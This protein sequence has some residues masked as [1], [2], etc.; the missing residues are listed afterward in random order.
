MKI[1]NKKYTVLSTLAA[2]IVHSLELAHKTSFRESFSIL[3]YRLASLFPTFGSYHYIQIAHIQNEQVQTLSSSYHTIL[4]SNSNHIEFRVSCQKSIKKKYQ[5]SCLS[6]GLLYPLSLCSLEYSQSY[7]KKAEGLSTISWWWL[8][9]C[10]F[11]HR[12][13]ILIL[14]Q[15]P[16]FIILTPTSSIHARLMCMSMHRHAI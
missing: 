13:F 3:I 10:P 15:T 7:R 1:K 14:L 9:S 5:Q 11:H 16:C 2:M 6:P 12:T 4:I 8:V